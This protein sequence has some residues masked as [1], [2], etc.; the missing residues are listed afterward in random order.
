MEQIQRRGPGRPRLHPSPTDEIEYL[1]ELVRWMAPQ[2]RVRTAA[3]QQATKF[4]RLCQGTKLRRSQ[5]RHDDIWKV[6]AEAGPRE[7]MHDEGV[8]TD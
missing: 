5:C 1:R 6:A 7:L 8:V 2:I 3:L 4:C